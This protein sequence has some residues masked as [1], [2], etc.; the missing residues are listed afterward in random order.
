MVSR[1]TCQCHAL[2]VGIV[3]N[4]GIVIANPMGIGVNTGTYLERCRDLREDLP[5]SAYPE[6]CQDAGY[7][8]VKSSDPEGERRCGRGVLEKRPVT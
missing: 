4:D 7:R 1:V 6:K 2:R 5:G 3:I 8:D